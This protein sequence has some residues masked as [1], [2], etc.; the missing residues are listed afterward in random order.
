MNEIEQ[1]R[2]MSMLL[3]TIFLT[4]AAF[5]TQMVLSRLIATER[6]E[7]GLLKAFGYTRLQVA[8]HYARMVIAI[9]GIGILLGW[10]LGTWLGRYQT[11]LYAELYRFSVSLF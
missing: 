10:V 1:M 4:V 6:S 11:G 2:T 9:S 3:P 7:I 5:L 8:W